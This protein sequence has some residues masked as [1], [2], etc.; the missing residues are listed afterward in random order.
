MYKEK[1]LSVSE[2]MSTY[3]CDN[4]TTVSLLASIIGSKEKAKR[5]FSNIASYT[6]NRNDF[7]AN[8]S[9]KKFDDIMY[10][11]NLT[12]KETVRIMAAL[13]LCKR[14]NAEADE[15]HIASPSEAVILLKKY[16]AYETHEK[17]LVVL[18]NAKNMVT[19]VVQVSEGSLTNSTVHPREVFAPAITDHAASIIVSHNHPSGNPNPS[20]EDDDLTDALYKAGETLGI[21]VLDHII[22]A[23][24][25]VYSYKNGHRKCFNS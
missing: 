14:F 21:P 10:A 8:L 7:F 19:R 9:R 18:L 1:E 6:D 17:I 24:N 13:E 15:N 12:E 22:I 3:G 16:L 23:K 2:T 20:K 5:L 25:R 4:I 11:G